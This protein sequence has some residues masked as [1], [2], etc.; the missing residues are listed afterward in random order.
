MKY[1]V[2]SLSV[3]V[4]GPPFEICSLKIGITEPE[5]PKK[6]PNLTLVNFEKFYDQLITLKKEFKSKLNWI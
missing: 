4:T 3:T 6:L 2:V 1:L 5:E